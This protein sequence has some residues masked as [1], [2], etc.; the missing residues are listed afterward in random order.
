MLNVFNNF[1]DINFVEEVNIDFN[2]IGKQKMKEK[3]ENLDQEL[4]VK[5][6]NQLIKKSLKTL[7]LIF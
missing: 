4:S 5:W 1:K 2:L 3:Y 6:I 7:N